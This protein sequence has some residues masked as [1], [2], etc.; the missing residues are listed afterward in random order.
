MAQLA[1]LLNIHCAERSCGSLGRNINRRLTTTSILAGNKERVIIL[2]AGWGGFRVAKDLDKNQ[3]DVTIISPRNHFL[4]TPFLP[5]T[6]VGTLEFRCVQEPVRTILG[7]HY[8]QAQAKTIDFEGQEIACSDVYS[9]YQKG[10]PFT[11]KREISFTVPYDKLVIA[12]GTK[13]NTFGVPGLISQ[14]EENI[15]TSGTNK[16]NVFFLKQLEHSRAIRNR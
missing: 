12:V 2:G 1:Q 13:S 8:H 4:F 11:D 14:E 15:G 16:D 7:V 5:S 6:S 3:Y 9:H 10:K